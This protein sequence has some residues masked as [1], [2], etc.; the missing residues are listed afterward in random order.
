V[1]LTIHSKAVNLARRYTVQNEN[2]LLQ[3]DYAD[4]VSDS[5]KQKKVYDHAFC[6]E[7]AS[8]MDNVKNLPPQCKQY[9]DIVKDLQKR[10]R[11]NVE[12]TQFLS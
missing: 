1:E 2:D 8:H 3:E 9:D 12:P 6:N 7:L 11:D 4:D 10:E 5:A